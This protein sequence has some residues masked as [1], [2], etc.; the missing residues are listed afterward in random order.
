MDRAHESGT[1]MIIRMSLSVLVLVVTTSLTL[2][3]D[4]ISRSLSETIYVP[5]Y[6]QVMTDPKSSQE[7]AVTIVIHNIDPHQTLTLQMVDYYDHQGE[8]VKT[9]L[10]KEIAITPFGS[11]K[12]VIGIRDRTGGA[13]AN[14]L[15]K[16]V[17]ESPTN[18]PI[19]EA[20]MIGGTGTQGISFTSRGQIIS[21]IVAAE[22]TPEK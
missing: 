2:A 3:K 11:W 7:M 16:W 18:S 13:G 10:P 21:R 14:F 20:L 8:R 4:G 6:S 1:V 17:S 15:V 9:L 5:A 12:S 19:A 22:T